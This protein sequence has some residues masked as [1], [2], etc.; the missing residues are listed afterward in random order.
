MVAKEDDMLVEHCRVGV[1][2][3]SEIEK[4]AKYE[5]EA[6]TAVEEAPPDEGGEGGEG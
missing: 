4:C 3:R 6:D 2:H 1:Q 5:V